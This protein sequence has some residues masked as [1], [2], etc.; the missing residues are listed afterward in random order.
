[1]PSID[2]QTPPCN[3]PEVALFV[4]IDIDADLRL[5]P[6]EEEHAD[7]IFEIVC[8]NR[9]RLS[10]WM[11]W[12]PAILS[13]DDVHAFIA[14][15]KNR[16]QQPGGSGEWV[17]MLDGGAVGAV[18]C[19]SLEWQDKRTSIGAW[20]GIQAQGRGVASR[21]MNAII[22]RLFESGIHRI[23]AFHATGNDRSD[24]M[25]RRL[26]FTPEG[27]LRSHEWLHEKPVDDVIMSLLATDHR[28]EPR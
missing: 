19:T 12:A 7:A 1:M 20:L 26:G 24:A 21:A 17:I 15:S 10:E 18:G 25:L 27:V 11:A 6:F 3:S 5:V 9:E 8:T 23:E 14:D 2:R 22:D 13:I 16:R 28:P 4:P